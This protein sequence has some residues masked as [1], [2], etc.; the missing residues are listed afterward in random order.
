MNKATIITEL[1]ALAAE[2]MPDEPEVVE[3]PPVEEPE[4][5]AKKKKAAPPEPRK[6]GLLELDYAK[7]GVHVDVQ[8]TT[9]QVVRGAEILDN[10]GLQLES[11]TGVDWIKE[12]ELEVVYDFSYTGGECF[13]V[14]LRVRIPRDEPN[15][16]TLNDVFPSANWHERETYDFFGINFEGHPQLENLLL[17]EDSDFHPLLKDFKG[18]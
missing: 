7:R 15:I 5:G 17:P 6:N 9:D 14:V 16:P 10:E 11:I 8:M 2:G 12:K 1:K 3:A 4:E 13:R 18:C